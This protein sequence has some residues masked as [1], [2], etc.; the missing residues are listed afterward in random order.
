MTRP[1]PP[2]APHF[3]ERFTGVPIRHRPIRKPGIRPLRPVPGELRFRDE[4]SRTFAGRPIHLDTDQLAAVGVLD[5]LVVDFHGKDPF[6]EVTTVA[7]DMDDV[8]Q[9]EP[10]L[11]D[12]DQGRLSSREIVL[13]DADFRLPHSPD[14]FLAGSPRIPLPYV[15][16]CSFLARPWPS[17]PRVGFI[18]PPD[19]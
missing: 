8:P 2:A 1:L 18:V 14:T 16:K 5:R 13:Y 19:A 6:D 9:V 12:A 4:H 15:V 17:R 7:Y 11:L 3:A 10:S